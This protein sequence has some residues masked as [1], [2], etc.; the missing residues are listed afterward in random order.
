MAD[1]ERAAVLLARD[2]TL[3]QQRTPRGNTALHV[4]SQ[5]KQNDPDFNATV[6]I[7][8]RPDFRSWTGIINMFVAADR[9]LVL[10]FV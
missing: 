2:P 9:L 3:A 5:A 6:A 4:V 7:I 1:T 8:E 10:R